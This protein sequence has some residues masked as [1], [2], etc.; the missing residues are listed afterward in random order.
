MNGLEKK[1]RMESNREKRLGLAVWIKNPRVAKHLRKFGSI[2]Y[3]SKRLNYVSM[4]VGAD[5]FENTV[6]QME[7]LPFVTRIERSHRHEIP[8]TYNNAKP[9]KAKEFDYHL[10]KTQLIAL[11]EMMLGEPVHENRDKSESVHMQPS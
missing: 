10:E 4:Y 7:K 1:I 6:R 11:T 3:V 8:T 5:V 9:D 2:H